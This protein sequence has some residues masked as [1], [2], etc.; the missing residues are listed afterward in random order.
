MNFL[1]KYKKYLLAALLF[2]VFL[3]ITRFISSIDFESLKTYLSKTPYMFVGVLA[4]S[5]FAYLFSTLAWKLCMGKEGQKISFTWLFIYRQVGEM[6]SLFNPTSIV[7]G[8]SLKAIILNKNGISPKHGVSSILL[9]RVLV[10][11]AGFFLICLSLLY[12]TVGHIINGQNILLILLSVAI[13]VT[14]VYVVLRFLVHP[15]L[16][17]GKTAEKLKNKTGWSFVTDNLV[18]S[19]YEMN[20]ISADFFRENKGKFLIAFLL[21]VAHWIFGAMEFYIVLNMMGL[22]VPLI[23]AIAVEM[24][25]IVFKTAGAIVPGQIGIEEYGNKVMLD[26]IGIVSNEIWLVVT[27]MR[28]GR[29]LFWLIVAGIFTPIISKSQKS[30]IQKSPKGQSY[31]QIVIDFPSNA[32]DQKSKS[33]FSEKPHNSTPSH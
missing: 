28:R 31:H 29:Q 13:V 17:L 15:K 26:V 24:G 9:H 32:M 7:A 10:I 5:L 16:F 4:A 3:L 2:S 18:T 19:V 33:D 25:V 20:E 22:D 30:P 27:L 21:C 23:K 12:L 6:L 14:L 1:K 11:F 8:E